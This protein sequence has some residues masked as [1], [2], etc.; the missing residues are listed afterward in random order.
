MYLRLDVGALDWARGRYLIGIDS[1]DRAL[2]DT[3]LPRTGAT[4]PVGLEF[5]LD[6]HGPVGSHLLVDR[7]YA[8]Y[9]DVPLPGAPGTFMNV[10]NRPFR[11]VANA[12]GAWET[13]WVET[14]RQRLG[15]DGTVFPRARVDRGLLRHARQQEHSLADWYAD[16]ATGTI[17]VRIPWGMLH[18]LDPSSRHVLQGA[19]PSS[20]DPE[21]TTTDGFRFVV[22]S[23]DPQAPAGRGDRLP[24]DP[25]RADAFGAVPTWS[26]PTWEEPRWHA[27][28]KPVLG[29]MR[30]AFDAIR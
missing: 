10:Y 2:G 1:Y 14:N 20:V 4:A 24:R 17:E 9:R 18:V 8:L 22:Q 13:T 7:P 25:A 15:R 19:S 12:A 26:W 6:L 21:G 5:V 11:T 16:A 30:A 27:A 3:R 29:A 23:Y 28:V